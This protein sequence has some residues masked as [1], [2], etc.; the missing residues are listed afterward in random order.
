MKKLPWKDREVS[1]DAADIELSYE[2]DL[3][4]AD[5]DSFAFSSQEIEDAFCTLSDLRKK[6]LELAFVQEKTSSEI[7]HILGCPVKYVYTE[8][9]RALHKLRK[10]IERLTENER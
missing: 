5:T 4:L 9:N 6:V 3:S 1:F 7:A 2:D 8:K 10:L